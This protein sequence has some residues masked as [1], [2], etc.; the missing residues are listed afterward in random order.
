M[1]TR[2]LLERHFNFQSA[3]VRR[4]AHTNTVVNS[5]ASSC[6][7]LAATAVFGLCWHSLSLIPCQQVGEETPVTGAQPC[8]LAPQSQQPWGAWHEDGARPFCV[9]ACFNAAQRRGEQSWPRQQG[10]LFKCNQA[11]NCFW[12]I[13]KHGTSQTNW[14]F[15]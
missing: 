15:S 1:Y 7:A 2:D 5:D 11:K 4:F 6:P 10:F 14:N 13:S 12:L 3:L 9:P 8:M